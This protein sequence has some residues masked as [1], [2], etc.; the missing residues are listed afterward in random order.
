M[1]LDL[2]E[3]IFRLL[4]ALMRFSLDLHLSPEDLKS[5]EFMESYCGRHISVVND[6]LSWEKEVKKS[7]SGHREGSV[8]CSAVKVLADET[9]LGIDAAKRVLWCIAREWEQIFDSAVTD[10]LAAPQ[11]CSRAVMNY[12]KGLQYQM[13]GNEKWSMVTLRYNALD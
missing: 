5:M 10:K 4:S 12:M 11:G 8:L 9:G 7:R 6:I 1:H 3:R 2:I 13:S